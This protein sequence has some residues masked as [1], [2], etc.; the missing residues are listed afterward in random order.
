VRVSVQAQVESTSRKRYFPS[1]SCTVC[2]SLRNETRNRSPHSDGNSFYGD[3]NHPRRADL[4]VEEVS[5]GAAA[6]VAGLVGEESAAV[7][8]VD[9]ESVDCSPEES[10]CLKRPQP[11]VC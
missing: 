10:R 11:L 2:R 6:V 9:Q 4:A 5:E 3:D 7:E 8:Q 1:F